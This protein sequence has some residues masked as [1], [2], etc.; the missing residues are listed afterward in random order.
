M[1]A[2]VEFPRQ[3]LRQARPVHRF[4]HI[5]QFNGLPDLVG[6]QG[7]DQM[8]LRIGEC[9][10]QVRPFFRRFLHTVFT[11]YAVTRRQHGARPFRRMAL[12]DGDQRDRR[13]VA[14]GVPRGPGYFGSNIGQVFGEIDCFSHNPESSLQRSSRALF[15]RGKEPVALHRL[16]NDIM[17]DMTPDIQA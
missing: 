2:A 14:P 17:L 11:E 10:F 3:R 5:E 9:R 15:P 6:L 4:D 12:A 1:S 16:Y 7:S 8:D 13:R